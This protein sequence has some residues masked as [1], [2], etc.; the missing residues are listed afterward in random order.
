MSHEKIIQPSFTVPLLPLSDRR[1][2]QLGPRTKLLKIYGILTTWFA[3]WKQR[4]ALARLD[5]RLL[6]DIGVTREQANR[7]AAKP[8]WRD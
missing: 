4:R 6:E 5:G 7:E 8:F 1:V 2:L 3:R